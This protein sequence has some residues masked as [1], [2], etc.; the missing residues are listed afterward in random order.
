MKQIN[1]NGNGELGKK[2]IGE[3]IKAK[4]KGGRVSSR[5]QGDGPI[6]TGAGKHLVD[7]EHVEGVH[8]D[9]EVE[10]ITAGHLG[11]VLV[12]ADTG[13]LKSLRGDLLALEGDEVDASG[14]LV[15]ISLLLAEIEDADLGVGDTTAV[16]G[17]DVGL[18]L[19]IAVA[20]CG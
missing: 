18:A 14:E 8:T 5:K 10:T 17:F 4:A 7:A 13:S 20:G 11:D 15:D 1:K 19:A 6:G 12:G 9:A 3:K 16:A 2:E